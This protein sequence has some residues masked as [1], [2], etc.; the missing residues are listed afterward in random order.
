VFLAVEHL[1]KKLFIGTIEGLATM[2]VTI[3]LLLLLKKMEV[4]FEDDTRI[5]SST[6]SPDW[7]G[8]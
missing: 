2:Y 7:N 1:L 3:I 8:R 5:I 6:M 4:L